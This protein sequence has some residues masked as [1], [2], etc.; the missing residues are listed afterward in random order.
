MPV[1]CAKKQIKIWGH[2]KR[3]QDSAMANYKEMYRML[4]N[5]I[6][7]TIDRLSIIHI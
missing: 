5:E 7:D 1:L 4:F 3:K 2:K 6:T